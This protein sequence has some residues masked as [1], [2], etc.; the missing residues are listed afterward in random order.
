MTAEERV[1][2]LRTSYCQCNGRG[3]IFA[4][5]CDNCFAGAIRAAAVEE[6]EECAALALEFS[7]TSQG[8]DTRVLHGNG[9]V[10]R[11]ASA[12]RARGER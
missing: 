12:I 10:N 9:M 7:E 1:T 6:R 2:K 11:I 4:S 8:V 3:K 5:L